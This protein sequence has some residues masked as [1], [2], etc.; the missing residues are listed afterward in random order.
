MPKARI[1][2]AFL[3]ALNELLMSSEDKPAHFLQNLIQEDLDSGKT[4]AVVTRFPPEPNGYLHIGHAQSIWLNFGLAEQFGGKCNL[5]FDDTNPEKESIEYVEAIK[6]D[7]AWLGFEWDGEPKYASNYF[8]Q[9]YL[10]A[11]HLISIGKAYVCEL[12]AEEARE[13]RGDFTHPG[14]NSPYRDRPSSESL[15]LL[16]KMKDGEIAEGQASLR[17][18]IDM[19]SGN[20][21]MRDP[22]LYRIRHV[23]H[24]NTGCLL[25]TSPS[26]RDLSTS[27]MPSS[28]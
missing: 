5:R 17:A 12:N 10:W 3:I 11:Q 14:K 1:I 18:K 2:P 23:H 26:P 25:Y 7:V 8:D 13:Y 4:K 16:E 27:R 15:E 24:H 9:L 21:N 19:S 28:A 20:M 22:V 6:R